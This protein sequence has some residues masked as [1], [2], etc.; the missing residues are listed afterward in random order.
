MSGYMKTPCKHCPFRRDVAP[1]LHPE[2][3]YEIAMVAYNRYASFACHKT[4]EYD[5]DTDEMV[6]TRDSKECAGMLSMRAAIGEEIPEG[7]E[8]S[9]DCYEDADEMEVAYQDEWDSKR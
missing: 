5:E 3:A 9:A 2:R 6:S 4:T 7:F 8:P 1:F